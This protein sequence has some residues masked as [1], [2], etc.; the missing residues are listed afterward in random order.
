VKRYPGTDRETDWYE[1]IP[2]PLGTA[3]R[4]ALT[5]EERARVLERFQ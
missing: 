3:W 4:K 1:P 5:P 2:V